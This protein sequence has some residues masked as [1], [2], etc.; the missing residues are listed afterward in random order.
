MPRITL[1]FR[2]RDTDVLEYSPRLLSRTMIFH[3]IT[4][5]FFAVEFKFRSHFNVFLFSWNK[6]EWQTVANGLRLDF[7]P[8]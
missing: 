5:C 1:S 3:D 8:Y 2:F 6:H 4:D 7:C